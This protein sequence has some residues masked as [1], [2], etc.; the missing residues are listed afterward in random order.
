MQPPRK[1]EIRMAAITDR[2]LGNFGVIEISKRDA[3]SANLTQITNNPHAR[4]LVGVDVDLSS[5]VAQYFVEHL[6]R[7]AAQ[8]VACAS[9][10]NKIRVTCPA[11]LAFDPR[12]RATS[13]D[14][15]G[16]SA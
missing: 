7:Y 13:N 15:I 11:T 10:I 5:N 6:R 9:K 16:A 8:R 12:S 4:A 1:G 2:V 14:V 3:E